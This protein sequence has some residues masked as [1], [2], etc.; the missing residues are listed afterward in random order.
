MGRLR[1][2]RLGARPRRLSLEL[3]I[4]RPVQDLRWRES[5]L[6]ISINEAGYRQA[7]PL[8]APFYHVPD[9]VAETARMRGRRWRDLAERYRSY[10]ARRPPRRGPS[11]SPSDWRAVR[12]VVRRGSAKGA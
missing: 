8:R 9:D 7:G 2:R 12:P 5:S 10:P 4:D 6:K 3:G 11:G 1:G